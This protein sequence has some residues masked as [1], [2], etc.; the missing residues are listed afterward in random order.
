LLPMFFFLGGFLVTGSAYRLRSVRR[1]LIFRALRIFPAL[2]VEVSLSAIILGGMVTT[3]PLFEYYTHPEFLSYFQNVL[4]FVHYT[5]P[6]VFKNHPVVFMN[7]NLWT[8]PPDF[9][10]YAIMAVLLATGIV[11]H[12][13]VFLAVFALAQ[14]FFILMLPFA[15]NWGSRGAVFVR[16]DM[17]I[18]S[19]FLGVAAYVFADRIYITKPFFILS[20]FSLLFFEYDRATILGIWGVC[21]LALCIGFLDLRNFPLIRRGDY[22]YGIYLYGYPIQQ[23]LWHYVPVFRQWWYMAL[24]ALP[25]TILFSVFSWHFIEKPCLAL[26]RKVRA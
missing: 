20:L 1:F 23:A 18:Y 3:L 11:L 21:Y 7:A 9:H 16:E 17:L 8:L 19:F 15:L 5:L 6:G 24:A 12:R 25:V 14:F 22:S 4:G 13:K 2:L 26:K 10:G